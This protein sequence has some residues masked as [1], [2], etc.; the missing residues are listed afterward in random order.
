M[1]MTIIR[2]AFLITIFVML[3]I[4]A[5]ISNRHYRDSEDVL[6]ISKRQWKAIFL[7]ML[8]TLIAILKR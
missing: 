5:F 6:F 3:Y 7:L 4:V 2:I 1:G 8:P